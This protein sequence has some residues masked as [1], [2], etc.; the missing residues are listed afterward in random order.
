MFFVYGLHT[1]IDR[2]EL[3]RELGVVTAGCSNHFVIIG[4]FNSIFQLNNRIDGAL[5][6]DSETQYMASFILEANV[7]EAPSMGLFYSWTN[8]GVGADTTTSRIDRAFVNSLNLRRLKSI[9]FLMVSL[10]LLLLLKEEG[11]LNL[12]TF[13]VSMRILMKL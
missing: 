4:D 11:L 1:I 8:K 13:C 9:I 2:K 3:W 5:V 10:C 7:I 6:S 12:T